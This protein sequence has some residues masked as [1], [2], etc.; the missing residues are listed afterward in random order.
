MEV[1]R[2]NFTTDARRQ[3]DGLLTIT[4][5]RARLSEDRCNQRRWN[6]I[7]RQIPIV[8]AMDIGILGWGQPPERRP[9][10]RRLFSPARDRYGIR[11]RLYGIDSKPQQEYQGIFLRRNH[12]PQAYEPEYPD[13]P[14][15]DEYFLRSG[16]TR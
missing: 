14:P 8:D 16:R 7:K 6:Q 11:K 4:E 12:P 9:R 5:M 2:I 3:Q 15:I 1:E 10:P 13:G